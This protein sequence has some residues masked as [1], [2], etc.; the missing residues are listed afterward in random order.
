MRSNNP[1]V[2]II[3]NMSIVESSE[4]QTQNL[5]LF[6]FVSLPA[7]LL[8]IWPNRFLA[9]ATAAFILIGIGYQITKRQFKPSFA[10]TALLILFTGSSIL[11]MWAAYQPNQALTKLQIL[12]V[13][14]LLALFLSNSKVAH[15]IISAHLAIGSVLFASAFLAILAFN[16]DQGEL[17]TPNR[18]A[19]LIVILAPFLVFSFFNSDSKLFRTLILGGSLVILAALLASGSRGGITSLILGVA[20][21]GVFM[22]RLKF[23]SE[24]YTK[25]AVALTLMGLV[26]LGT[27]S[28]F[29]V[30]RLENSSIKI[31]PGSGSRLTLYSN[32]KHLIPDYWLLG[33]GLNSFSGQYSQYVL[34]IPH[35]RFTYGHNLYFDLI[36]EQ[37]IV[38]FISF[39]MLIIATIVLLLIQPIESLAMKDRSFAGAIL[40]SL[41]AFILHG[42][43]DDAIYSNAGSTMLFIAPALAFSLPNRQ[44][45]IGLI[46]KINFVALIGIIVFAA[47]FNRKVISTWHA[48]LA[49][50][51]MAKIQL[52]D[53]PTGEWSRGETV[54]ELKSLAANF[55]LALENDRQNSSALYRLG[56]ISMEK[57]DF[58]KAAEYFAQAHA[59]HSSHTGISKN[60]GY[61]LL[62][63]GKPDEA[64]VY[65]NN[66]EGIRNELDAY[67]W[68]WQSLDR[69]DLSDIAKT[70]QS[71][72]KLSAGS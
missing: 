28:L 8:C 40:A 71:S 32:L 48:N 53:W 72:G 24:K 52:A 54:S 39:S 49:A 30:E 44:E 35:L 61:A 51:E 25:P 41:T 6:T 46:R 20:L 16:I 69:P 55:E 27:L 13:A 59:L 42:F 31:I 38:G 56:L 64:Q 4:N 12:I 5:Y 60:L 67:I 36:L 29:I 17:L 68:W 43:I 66:V 7:F 14:V 23:I 18:L 65:L 70:F 34:S 22:G 19:G 47:V 57:H 9:L 50:I 15:S 1:L 10:L 3:I 21:W 33:G 45:A 26:G 2:Q 37:G 11:G 63:S 58:S 62:W